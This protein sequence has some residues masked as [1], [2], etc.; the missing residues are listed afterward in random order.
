M[1]KTNSE[2][3]SLSERSV[4]KQSEHTQSNYV[5]W[6]ENIGLE[7]IAPF[8][9]EKKVIRVVKTEGKT[10][11]REAGSSYI[12]PESRATETNTFLIQRHQATLHGLRG[13]DFMFVACVIEHKPG[14]WASKTGKAK[15]KKEGTNPESRDINTGS[16]CSARYFREHP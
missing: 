8:F 14:L 9:H 15:R 10:T 16:S 12:C 5:L 11:V 3:M 13:N 6:G 1:K 2:L 4:Q 7:H